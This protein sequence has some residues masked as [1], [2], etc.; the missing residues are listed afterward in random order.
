LESC[1]NGKT[2]LAGLHSSAALPLYSGNWDQ[3]NLRRLEWKAAI[4]FHH[5]SAP[6]RSTE[7][8][9]A[10]K[11]FRA[12]AC[13]NASATSLTSPTASLLFSPSKD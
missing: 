7:T 3:M 11:R 9:V 13:G 8:T 4:Q 1:S 6:S 12:L 5:T 10:E 2:A